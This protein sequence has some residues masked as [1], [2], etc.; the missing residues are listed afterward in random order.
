MKGII[1]AGGSG[2][3][4]YPITKAISKQINPIYDKPMIY[5][6]L[7][8]LMLAGIRE[9]LVISTPRDLPLFQ[10]LLGNGE[11]FGIRFEY[12][13]QEKPNGLAEAFII[14]EKFI[15]S[16]SCALVL[17]DNIFYGHGLTGILK[18]AEARK[19]GA[20]IFGYYVPN[21][22]DFGVVEFDEN[23]KVISLEEKPQNPKSNYA[24]PGLYFY[25]NTVV[26]KAKIVKPSKRGELEITSINEMYLQE[27][28]LHVVNFGR[29]MAWLDTGTHD[30]LLEAANFVKTIQSRQGVMVA[31]LEEIA[32]RNGWISKEKVLELAKP[33]MKSKYGEYLVNLVK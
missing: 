4:L 23:G 7:S 27:E 12:A 19:E 14:G 21:P 13:I 26:E 17:G 32:Y 10:E 5:Y 15:D 11:N 29:G 30:A 8:I 24:V 18:E 25:D 6:P 20:T 16:D 1:L 9:I 2:T 28:K 3:R 22:K 31:C 33:L